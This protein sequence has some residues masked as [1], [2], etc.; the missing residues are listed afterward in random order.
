MVEY[1]IGTDN[2]MSDVI[3]TSMLMQI[4]VITRVT[5]H[6]QYLLLYQFR[7][8]EQRERRAAIKRIIYKYEYSYKIEGRFHQLFDNWALFQMLWLA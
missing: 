4:N 1:E 5:L 6:E 2:D 7:T 8:A 3:T